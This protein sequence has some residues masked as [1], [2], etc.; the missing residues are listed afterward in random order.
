MWFTERLS[1]TK[2]HSRTTSR[3]SLICIFDCVTFRT[4]GMSDALE[5]EDTLSGGEVAK[6]PTHRNPSGTVAMLCPVNSLTGGAA[7]R[8][9]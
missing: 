2:V 7:T 3:K 1:L 5:K 6:S 9:V 8:S 4:N